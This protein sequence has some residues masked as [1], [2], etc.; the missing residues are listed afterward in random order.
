MG[1]SY[2]VTADGRELLDCD[3]CGNS[4]GVRKIRC[5][6]GYCQAI[7]ICPKCRAEHPEYVSKAGHKEQGCERRHEAFMAER[8]KEARLIA[9]G[10]FVRCAALQ[11]NGR[12]KVCFRG[13]DGA[14]V[15]YWM[16]HE[17]YDALPLAAVF[18]V[19]DYEKYGPL[20]RAKVDNL[21]E[22]EEKTP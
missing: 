9:E 8:E 12:V 15:Y 7:A 21:H 11:H 1:Y 17:T 18:A 14:E 22:S 6:F 10:R 2:T 5:P 19:E 13:K 4:G 3:V 16:S 20:T